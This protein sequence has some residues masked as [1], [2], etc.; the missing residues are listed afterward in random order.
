[1]PTDA[2]ARYELAELDID[3]E[4]RITATFADGHVATFD[5]VEVRSAC[6]CATC[7][8]LRDRGEEAWP[9]PSSPLPLSISDASLHGGWGLNITW[10]DGHSTGIY[11]FEV[12]RRWSEARP[13]SE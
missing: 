5:L 3:R 12:L 7:R 10:N 8:A 6:P 2:D 11:P 4:R 1:M 9:R 13:D